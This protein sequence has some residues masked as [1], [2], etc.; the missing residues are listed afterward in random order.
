MFAQNLG[1]QGALFDDVDDQE[2]YW[3]TLMKDIVDEY[4]PL[5]KMRVR[6]E[7]VP[8]ITTSWKNAITGKKKSRYK[9]LQRQISAQL[10]GETKVSQ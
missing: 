4:F 7:D 5:K 6:S 8:Y 9:V 10:G 3:K 1:F 2:Y